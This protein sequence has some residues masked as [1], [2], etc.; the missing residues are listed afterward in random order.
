MEKQTLPNATLILVFGILSIL[1]A[2]CCAGLL[3][4]I[5]GIITLVMAKNTTRIYQEDPELYT[6]EQNVRTGR[7]LAII[8][9]ILS[10]LILL[11]SLAFLGMYGFEGLEEVQREAMGGTGYEF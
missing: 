2:F 6:G 1:G 10:G 5:F 3:G 7:I 4:V 11:A 8:G 9:L